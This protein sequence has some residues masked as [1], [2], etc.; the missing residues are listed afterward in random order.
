[1]KLLPRFSFLLALLLFSFA[2]EAKKNKAPKWKEGNYSASASGL[3]YRLVKKGKGDSIRADDLV[4]AK[5]Y[6]YKRSNGKLVYQADSKNPGTTFIQMN[7]EKL[8]PGVVESI[9]MLKKG[10]KG[11]FKIP[12][13]LGKRNSPDTIFCFIYIEKTAHPDTSSDAVIQDNS[14]DSIGFVL[15]DPDLDVRGDSLFHLMKLVEAPRMVPCGPV[16][17][18][19]AFKFRMTWFENGVQHK[20]ILIYVDCPENYG[21]DYFVTGGMY[22]VTAIPLAENRKKGKTVFNQYS[23]EKLEA[24]WGLR[25]VK[26]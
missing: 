10:G 11:Y 6:Q 21:K 19:I 20:D 7:N 26:K 16:K 22:M 1:M 2:A 4:W 3:Q 25:I 13:S 14:V 18:M 17:T 8:L 12:P 5:L 23:E 9:R 24:Y 15:T